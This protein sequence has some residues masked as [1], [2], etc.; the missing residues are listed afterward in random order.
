MEKQTVYIESSVVS[1][2]TA[3]PSRDIVIAGHQQT[4]YDWWHLWRNKFDCFISD[5][6]YDEIS[7]GDSSAAQKR[8]E[9]IENFKYL[10]FNLEIEN[11]GYEYFRLLNI[12]QKSRL[13]AL[14]L[15]VGVWHKIDFILSWNCK[16][17][18][19]AI[20]SK[21]LREFNNKMGFHTPILCTPEELTEEKYD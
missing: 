12:P 21:K 3:N 7:L 14:H 15:A 18:A 13:D 6:V 4:T 8:I 1:Y 17:I 19:N 9:A 20:V 10:E 5:L 2:L 11:L 16:H